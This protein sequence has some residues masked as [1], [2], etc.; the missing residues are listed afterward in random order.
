[1]DST[2]VLARALGLS[3]IVIGVSMAATRGMMLDVFRE[4][5]AS[6]ALSYVIGLVMLLLGSLLVVL[7]TKWHG[8]AAAV[9]TLM[10][11]AVLAESLVFVFS[12]PGVLSRYLGTLQ[13]TAVYHGIAVGYLVLGGYLTYF[14]FAASR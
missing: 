5:A 4:V 10:G 12:P 7:H 14:G 2:V 3:W 9:V 11:W 6:R 1:M 13:N 8:G